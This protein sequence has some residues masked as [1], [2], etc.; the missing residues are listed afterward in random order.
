MFLFNGNMMNYFYKTHIW[1]N[2]IVNELIKSSMTLNT[3]LPEYSKTGPPGVFF[4]SCLQGRR[5]DFQWLANIFCSPNLNLC[6]HNVTGELDLFWPLTSDHVPLTLTQVKSQYYTG[7]GSSS[8]WGGIFSVTENN[9]SWTWVDIAAVWG[10]TITCIAKL[11]Y[12]FES[13]CHV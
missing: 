5:L 9:S 13:M 2:F 11:F 12:L 1:R 3:L 10:E 4:C 7:N 6:C 8:F